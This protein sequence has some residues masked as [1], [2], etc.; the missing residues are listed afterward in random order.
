MVVTITDITCMQQLTTPIS[1]LT[2]LNTISGSVLWTIVYYA[3]LAMM[4]MS[5]STVWGI[6]RGMLLGGLFSFLFGLVLFV[7][8]LISINNLFFS[9]VLWLIG[10]FLIIIQ[11]NEDT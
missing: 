10:A 11:N 5:W 7:F 6:T 9:L 3:F 2:C 8:Q 4:V 1:L